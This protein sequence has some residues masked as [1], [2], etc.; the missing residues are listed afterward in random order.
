MKLCLISVKLPPGLSGT[1]NMLGPDFSFEICD[2]KLDNSTWYIFGKVIF[3]YWR[4]YTGCILG[5]WSTAH[6]V[7][8]HQNQHRR[9]R[10]IP[11]F[12]RLTCQAFYSGTCI[13]LTFFH[14]KDQLAQPVSHHSCG[15]LFSPKRHFCSRPLRCFHLSSCLRNKEVKSSEAS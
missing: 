5:F 1:R 14:K 4:M 6:K 11:T 7:C 12:S 13:T 2:Y 8:E 9:S 15:F 10:D 3:T